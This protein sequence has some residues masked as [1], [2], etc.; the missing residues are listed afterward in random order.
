MGESDTKMIPIGIENFEKLRKENFYY[1]DKTKLIKELLS[2]WAEVNLFTRP[3]R[4]GKSLNMSMLRCFFEIG[5]DPHIFDGLEIAKETELCE[6]Y[7]GKFPVI[8]VSLKGINA[9]SFET[10]CKMAAGLVNEAARKHIYLLESRELEKSEKKTF[11]LLLDSRMKEQEVCNSLRVL[12]ELLQKHYRQKVVLL[13]DEY[14]VPLAKAFAN[15][16]YDQMVVLVQNMFGQWLKTNYSLQFAVLTGC[17]RVAKESIFTGL[18]NLKVL[19]IADV[20]FDEYFGFTDAQVKELLAYYGLSGAYGDVKDWYDGYQFGNAHIYC[21]WDVLNYC[22]LLRADPQAPP[23]D[24]WSNTSGN[25]IIRHFIQ[26]AGKGTTK[27]ELE[28]LVAGEAVTKKVRNDLT[29]RDLYRSVEHIWSVLYTTGYLT[30]RGKPDGDL[31]SLVIPNMEIRKIFTE[32]I[33]EYFNETVKQDGTAVEQF[34]QA[35]QNGDAQGVQEQ[36]CQY[37]KKAVSIRDTFVKKPMKENYYHGILMG[38]LAY[39]EA[40]AVR[41][42]QESGSGYSD[43]LVELEEEETGIVIE[44]KYPDG[45]DL[46][47]GCEQALQQIEQMEYAQQLID[48]GMRTILKYGIACYKKQC[49]VKLMLHPDRNE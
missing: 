42:N 37:L 11:E 41:S 49:R 12:S 36:L 23:Q 14:D 26:Y 48:D 9:T 45:G 39:K 31:Y 20:R 32:Q 4:F 24:Y 40:W 27:Q 10:A 21:P 28:R 38:L 25:D 47:K 43:I 3:R 16:Y 46:E 29:Y 19:S 5:T 18:N 22:D 1:I 30:L 2:N 8:S 35:L 7:M 15:G 33:M 17:L 44:V 6:Q 34:C 13:I